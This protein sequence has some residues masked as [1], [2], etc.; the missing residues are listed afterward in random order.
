VARAFGHKAKRSQSY[1][2]RFTYTDGREN[3]ILAI[4]SNLPLDAFSHCA[5]YTKRTCAKKQ[6]TEMFLYSSTSNR[7]YRHEGRH[8][9]KVQGEVTLD[10]GTKQIR[11]S[12]VVT[13]R[14]SIWADDS[15]FMWLVVALRKSHGFSFCCGRSD[16][17][18]RGKENAC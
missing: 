13:A 6:H 9:Y 17:S 14:S 18:N 12:G 5:G 8:R 2:S 3:R 4:C 16:E 11:G 1:T 10:C 15:V 7:R